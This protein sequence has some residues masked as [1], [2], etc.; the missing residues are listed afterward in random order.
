MTTRV[1]ISV[2]ADS[3]L[4]VEAF[5]VMMPESPAGVPSFSQGTLVAPGTKREFFCY[6]GQGVYTRE[7]PKSVEVVAPA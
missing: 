6:S 3:A 5:A 1:T 4:G 7:V 2:E